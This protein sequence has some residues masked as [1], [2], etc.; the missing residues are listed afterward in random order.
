MVYRKLLMLIFFSYCFITAFCQSIG[1]PDNTILPGAYR[2]DVYLPY[3]KGKKVGVFANQ[4]SMVGQTHLVDTLRRLGVNIVKIFAPEHGFR[5][6]ANA[7]E[8]LNNDTDKQTGIPIISLYGKK[9]KPTAVDLN[10]VDVLVFD[11]Q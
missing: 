1:K 8:E 7:G 11:I 5:G 9:V 10:D 4:T 2:T 3:L 6:T